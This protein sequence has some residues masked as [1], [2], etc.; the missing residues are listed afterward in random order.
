[1]GYVEVETFLRYLAVELDVAAST[2]KQALSALLFLYRE[3]LNQPLNWVDVP[4][5]QKPKRLPVVLS[6]SEVQA[7]LRH[8]AGATLLIGQLFYGSG[9]PVNEC[10]RCR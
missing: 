3:V 9:L 10:L 8:L 6:R 2:Q 7:V 4:W 1:M 5:A